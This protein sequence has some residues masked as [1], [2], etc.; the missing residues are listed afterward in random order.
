MSHPKSFRFAAIFLVLVLLPL[1]AFAQSSNGSISGTITDESGGALPGVTV[2]ATK[3]DTHA[4]RDGS[5]D[6]SASK[7][8]VKVPGHSYFHTLRD[9]L[10]WGI[11]PNYRGEPAGGGGRISG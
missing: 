5:T 6:Q 8:L 3:T 10:R 1:G 2:T 9:K 4:T 11:A 7:R